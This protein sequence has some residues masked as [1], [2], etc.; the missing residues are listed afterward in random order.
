[1][2]IKISTAR[3]LFHFVKE[4]GCICYFFGFDY[5]IPF[6]CVSST[7]GNSC[8]VIGMSIHKNG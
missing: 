2:P 1:M 5:A 8:Y 3:S 4:N 7:T 6:S